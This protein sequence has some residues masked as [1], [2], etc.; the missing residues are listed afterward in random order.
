MEQSDEPGGIGR[1]Q[2]IAVKLVTSYCRISSVTVRIPIGSSTDPPRQ[3][4]E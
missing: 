3:L 1:L 4:T 2:V